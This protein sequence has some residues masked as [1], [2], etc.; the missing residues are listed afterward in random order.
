MTVEISI[1]PIIPLPQYNINKKGTFY[2]YKF[3]KVSNLFVN[4]FISF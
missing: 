3:V 1:I 2:H 4:G